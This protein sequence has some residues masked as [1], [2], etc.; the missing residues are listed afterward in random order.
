ML[1]GLLKSLFGSG[2][3]SDNLLAGVAAY[4]RG[5]LDVAS[6][7]FANAVT[8]APHNAESHLYAGLAC[9]PC[10]SALNHRNS[11]CADNKCLQ[12]ITVEEVL[13]HANRLLEDGAR[14]A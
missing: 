12:A 14:A 8:Q 11:P 9:S 10:L 1:G 13:A 3:S 6:R 5:E 7:L 4:H 2:T